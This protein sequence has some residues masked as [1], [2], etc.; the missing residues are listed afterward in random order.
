MVRRL[1]AWS[2]NLLFLDSLQPQKIYI[3]ITNFPKML[4]GF[5]VPYAF[6]FR[7]PVSR[8]CRRGIIFLWLTKFKWKEV[9]NFTVTLGKLCLDRMSVWFDCVPRRIDI[10]VRWKPNTHTPKYPIFDVIFM[11]RW[12]VIIDYFILTVMVGKKRYFCGMMVSATLK[13][14]GCVPSNF[15]PSCLLPYSLPSPIHFYFYPSPLFSPS[16]DWDS[17]QR[18]LDSL[19]LSLSQSSLSFPPPL[20]VIGLHRFAGRQ[21]LSW[22]RQKPSRLSRLLVPCDAR[23]SIYPMHRIFDYFLFWKDR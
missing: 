7:H 12:R 20:V 17:L 10:L 23:C 3:C 6:F 4:R 19:S 15:N 21:N 1:R 13:F 11:V 14:W 22:A 2:L 5:T 9:L 8:R 16:N 18:Y